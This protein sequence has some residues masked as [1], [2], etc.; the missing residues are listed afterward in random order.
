MFITPRQNMAAMAASTAEP[1]ALRVSLPIFEHCR[2]SVATACL[3]KGPP[4]EGGSSV[5]S[6]VGL[7]DSLVRKYQIRIPAIARRIK[8]TTTTTTSMIIF[9]VIL[10]Q[11]R[12]L[13]LVLFLN[14]SY[15]C[16]KGFILICPYTPSYNGSSLNSPTPPY[17]GFI[18]HFS[19]TPP[20]KGLILDSPLL[21]PAKGVKQ[22]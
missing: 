2:V 19:F 21:N 7:S 13:N 1:F 12:T 20:Y 17:S 10:Q 22:N 15:P 11:K 18:L 4:E 8:I 14:S 6:S 5:G 16:Y 9:F 3:K